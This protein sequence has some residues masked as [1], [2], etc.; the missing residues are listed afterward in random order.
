M[1]HVEVV[2][3]YVPYSHKYVDDVYVAADAKRSTPHSSAYYDPKTRSMRSNPTPDVH[4]EDAGKPN[5]VN[6]I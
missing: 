2:D 1:C 6:P 4:P 3:V 5:L